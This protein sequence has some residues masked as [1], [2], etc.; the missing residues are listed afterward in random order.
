MKIPK[1]QIFPIDAYER[2]WVC[3]SGRPQEFK[4]DKIV[5]EFVGIGR[6]GDRKGRDHKEFIQDY[7]RQKIKKLIKSNKTFDLLITHDKA[8]ISQ[9]GFGMTENQR[10][11]G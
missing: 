10:G 2:V 6:I 4:V 7:E 3:K 9:R 8:D 11:V 5:L 1:N